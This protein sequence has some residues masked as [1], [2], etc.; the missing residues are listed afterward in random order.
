MCFPVYPP[1]HQLR[2]DIAFAVGAYGPDSDAIFRKQKE[3]I[4]TF[5]KSYRHP[6]SNGNIRVAIIRYDR[7]A[8]IVKY[9]RET[10]DIESI[11]NLVN[12]LRLV[13][14]GSAIDTAFSIASKDVF[15]QSVNDGRKKVLLLFTDFT[16]SQKWNSLRKAI[17][18]LRTQGVSV[19]AMGTGNKVNI[20]N[21]VTMTSS[22]RN[23]IIAESSK[24]M[25][26]YYYD[27]YRRIL[28]SK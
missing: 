7:R 5:L 8:T 22:G 1:S 17:K 23:A 11:E 2:L 15:S 21:L 24:T 10:Y 12:G 3:F 13:Q 26:Y 9:L 28:E 25:M 4:L 6:I 19:I 27:I 20:P 14:R 16:E 18:L